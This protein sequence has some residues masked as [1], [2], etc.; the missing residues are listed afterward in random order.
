MGLGNKAPPGIAAFLD[1]DDY[2]DEEEEDDDDEWEWEDL[3][4]PLNVQQPR[5]AAQAGECL[6]RAA[7]HDMSP[8][9]TKRP[10]HGAL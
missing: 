7:L 1:D 6:I 2:D 8:V 5:G 4:A 9:S 3:D 10:S